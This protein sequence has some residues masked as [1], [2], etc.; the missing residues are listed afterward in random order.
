MPTGS[1]GASSTVAKV[2]DVEY[3]APFC[4]KSKTSK[5]FM[6]YRNKTNNTYF[7]NKKAFESNILSVTVKMTTGSAS[8]TA[9][10]VTAEDPSKLVSEGGESYTL[11]QNS[12]Q[13]YKYSVPAGSKHKAFRLYVT[14]EK[15]VQ[16]ESIKVEYEA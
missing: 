8:A 3:N 14:G 4:Y 6:M 10:I 1:P 9:C 2:G 13:L 7:E 11:K 15:N 5:F 12:M 16:V